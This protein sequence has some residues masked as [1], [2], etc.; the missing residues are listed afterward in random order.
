MTQK[1]YFYDG[2]ITGDASL[3]PYDNDDL[4]SVI[5]PLF[6][7]TPG[8][9]IYGFGA[10]YPGGYFTLAV[11]NYEEKT[12]GVSVD[13]TRGMIA[14]RGKIILSYLT[15]TFTPARVC[16]GPFWVRFAVGISTTEVPTF[17]MIYGTDKNDPP[18]IPSLDSLYVGNDVVLPIMRMYVP[19]AGDIVNPE[20]MFDERV[21][22][23]SPAH[24]TKYV[25]KN[26]FPNSELL[27]SVNTETVYTASDTP[28][29]NWVLYNIADSVTVVPY[30]TDSMKFERCT[31][32]RFTST[33]DFT[34]DTGTIRVGSSGHSVIITVQ[35]YLWVKS[36]SLNIY[37]GATLLNIALP[38]DV[39]ILYTTRIQATSTVRDINIIFDS[40]VATDFVVGQITAT[41]GYVACPFVPQDE[42]I[43]FLQQFYI[44]SSMYYP[45][46]KTLVKKFTSLM[47]QTGHTDTGSAGT[48]NSYFRIKDSVSGGLYVSAET[49][50]L[51]NSSPGTG[52]GLINIQQDPDLTAFSSD[53]VYGAEGSSQVYLY[54]AK[55]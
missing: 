24:Y 13:I 17:Y 16:A 42:Y 7:D 34:L 2:T 50:R 54:G 4:E 26:I 9:F 29:F 53:A 19:A 15:K 39:P 40:D 36:G 49:G 33:N 37:N 27:A 20:Y 55:T 11:L 12:A 22:I 21:F 38:T 41:E 48:D 31:P 32:L 18:E 6:S 8:G 46:E 30:V 3:A 10:G 1:S 52:H 47:V 44:S 45:Y 43:P 5:E 14:Y 35:F 51:P 28:V 25:T 23:Q